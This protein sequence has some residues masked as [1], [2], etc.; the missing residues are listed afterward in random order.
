MSET[1]DTSKPI[2][3][4]L[5][6][7]I[8]SCFLFVIIFLFVITVIDFVYAQD[9]PTNYVTKLIFGIFSFKLQ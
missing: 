3:S 7:I 5:S 1:P 8:I 9:D 2:Y 4:L 6:I